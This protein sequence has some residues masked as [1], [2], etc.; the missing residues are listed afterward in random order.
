M[1]INLEQ[2]NSKCGD[3]D[4]PLL[5]VLIQLLE[6]IKELEDRLNLN[7]SNSS[8][9][10]STEGFK[11]NNTKSLRE[12]SGKKQGGQSGHKGNGLKMTD[13]PDKEILHLPETCSLCGESLVNVEES[14]REK[15]QVIDIPKIISFITEHIV[16]TK[17]CPHCKAKAKKTFPA[18]IENNIQYGN[19]IKSLMTYI[20]QYQ[21]LPHKRAA[22]F[23]SD[24]CGVNISEATIV[25]TNNH[26]YDLLKQA[27]EKTK[28]LLLESPLV[29]KDETGIFIN[30]KLNWLHGTSTERATYYQAHPNRGSK[31]MDEDDFLPKYEGIVAHDFWKPYFNYEKISHSLCNAH[32]LRELKSVSEEN[33]Q[34]WSGKLIELLLEI[35]N[36]VLKAKVLNL[37]ELS[38]EE[39]KR[40]LSEYDKL[41]HEGFYF[42]TKTEKNGHKRGRGKQSKVFNL[43]TRFTNFKTD[44]LRF[45]QDFKAPFTNN[46]AERDI[47]MVKVKQKISGTF[48]SVQGS[49]TFCRIRGYISTLKKNK[50]S[51]FDEI[52][53]AFLKIPFI[54]SYA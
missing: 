45:M 30:G 24:I 23:I 21:L 13:V 27:E 36:S 28:N 40:F 54:P 50:T 32:L 46:Q 51:V 12:K 22:E 33:C 26:L 38:S 35:N 53:N 39:Q 44:I 5:P 10:P 14:S 19:S 8:K 1:E 6:R 48:R 18:G 42:N 9:P 3:K 4:C 17:E 20:T 15:R 25:N 52:L 11:R 16:V 2:F 7:S 37:L 41:I 29:H 31:A 34:A 49:K 43:L 47:R